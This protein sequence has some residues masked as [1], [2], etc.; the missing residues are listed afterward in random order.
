MRGEKSKDKQKIARS[1]GR[2][3]KTYD[4]VAQLQRDVA[5]KLLSFHT[6]Y[7]GI[8]AD[9]GCGTG[10]CRE[11]IS[12]GCGVKPTQIISLDLA[13]GMIEYAYAK[14][15]QKTVFTSVDQY[16]NDQAPSLSDVSVSDVN[17]ELSSYWAVAD[18]ESLPLACGSMDGLISSLSIQWS[19][20][21]TAVF[22]EALR[23]LKPGGWFYFST[24]GPNTL[25]E[26]VESW[27]QAD[28][29]YVHVNSFLPVVD[30]LNAANESGFYMEDFTCEPE[31]LFYRDALALMRELKALGAH[32]IN[33]GRNPG[34]MGRQKLRT[35]SKAYEKFR[36]MNGYLPASYEVVYVLLKKR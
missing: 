22:D 27:E 16:K 25:H 1:F 15:R 9:I 18:M 35:L 30:V 7:S 11:Q 33:D 6:D 12:Q 20:N 5:N 19:E 10:Y 4:G 28:P 26:L 34:L 23:V 29:H 32:N 14:S 3:A 17:S 2:A 31:T 13:Y 24:L 21:L 8:I 36:N